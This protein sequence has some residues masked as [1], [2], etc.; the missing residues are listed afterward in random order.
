MTKGERFR[1]LNH[2][3]YEGEIFTVESSTADY[4]ACYSSKRPDVL[5]TFAEYETTFRMYP[6]EWLTDMGAMM[7]AA[8]AIA[9]TP[10]GEVIDFSRTAQEFSEQG[11]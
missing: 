11:Q 7:A 9:N 5:H 8:N 10:Y 2:P 4:I 6:V 1:F 3:S